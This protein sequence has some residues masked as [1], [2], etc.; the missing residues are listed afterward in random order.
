MADCVH[1]LF[2][3]LLLLLLVVFD[4]FSCVFWLQLGDNL[5]RNLELSDR[6][7]FDVL[8]FIDLL[9]FFFHLNELVDRLVIG[10][11]FRLLRGDRCLFLS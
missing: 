9:Q 3:G 1:Q 11:L 10:L 8:Y 6:F 5:D 4:L 2:V 7:C